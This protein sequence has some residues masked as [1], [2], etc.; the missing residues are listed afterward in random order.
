MNQVRL[1][2]TGGWCA[3][4][5]LLMAGCPGREFIA[6]GTGGTAQLGDNASV[7]V[8]SPTG[9]LSINGGTPVEVAWQVTA[10]T[11]F[12]SIDVIFDIDGNPD[13]GNEISAQRNIPLNVSSALLST[14]ELD[15]ATYL[16][17]VILK[18][19]NQLA[20]F[21]YAPGRLVVN[22]APR[23]FFT[24]PRDNFT[25][26]RSEFVVPR[27]DVAWTLSDPDSDV[28]VQI[29][30]DPD[31]TPNGN[32]ILLRESSSP[33]GDEFSFDLP[34]ANFEPGVYRILAV[35]SDGVTDTPFY[36][37]G[38][39]R[40][41]SRLAGF[42]DL[43]NLGLPSSEI[44][45]A[46]FEGFNPRDNNGSFVGSARDVDGDGF[47]DFIM[48][49]QFGKP[50]FSANLQR[51]GV[52]EAYM[53]Y[54]RQQRFS[55]RVNVNSVGTLIRGE[56]YAGVPEATDPIRPSR[57]IT[58]FTTLSDWDNDGLREVAFGMPFTDSFPIVLLDGAGY[59]RSGCV[60][61]QSSSVF[62][63]NLGFPGS[64]PRDIIQLGTIGTLPHEPLQADPGCPEGFIGPKAPISTGGGSTLYW[65]HLIDA[66]P[67]TLGG[68][69]LGCRYS[70]EVFGDQ[71]GETVSGYITD[72][73][74]IS[75]PNRDPFVSV[76]N[77]PTSTPGA[78]V[79]SI[80]YCTSA[81]GNFPWSN[82]DSPPAGNGYAGMPQTLDASLIPHGGPYHY[83]M[84]SLAGSPGYFVDPDDAQDPCEQAFSANAPD[85]NL[86]VR[87]FAQSPGARLGG[88]KAIDDF[89]AD[90]VD[91][92]LIGTPLG[93]EGAGACFIVL[94]RLRNL[95]VGGEL[96]IEELSLPLN[97]GDPGTS[98]IFDGIRVVGAPNS[99][100]GQSQ[101]R[102]G[103]F[104]GDGVADV[105][106][107]SPLINNR[108][109]GAAVFFGSR[110]VI[111]LT[112]EE[113]PFD[114]L[115]RR[116]LGVN[117]AGEDEG[118]LAGAR[119]AG[120]GDVDGDGN[121][122]I[123]IAAPERTVALDT[124]QNG[125]L[126][127]NRKNCG[128]VYL[129]YGSPDL[130]GTLSLADVGTERLPGVIFIG[131]NS[132]DRLGAA[133]GEQGD[134]S[135]GIGAAGDVDGDGRLDLMLSSVKAS[136]RD[137][138]AAGEVYLIYGSGD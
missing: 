5:A 59:F 73:I 89:N 25:F 10:T 132:A 61:V 127:I 14:S 134:R 78:G 6:G 111:N 98:R 39:I 105:V 72:S 119:V 66:Q 84:D 86:T 22:Q 20:A 70:S 60:V 35:V 83:V 106:I 21:D 104:N 16:I 24:S 74:I 137:R 34:T 110:D 12:A 8:L 114:D 121:D 27:F 65:R 69:R 116:G 120:V 53:I 133:I 64:S 108:K 117:F 62:S 3:A 54:G 9:D 124:D 46:I 42:I 129:I 67:P 93:F 102:A 47:G 96:S 101:D 1:L 63:P 29:F 92:I 135:V 31:R 79:V 100:L 55:G 88:A 130:R 118:D 112:Q 52:G 4:A 125:T 107:G 131:R 41:R 44:P 28:T 7:N 23:L 18:E 37:P 76:F 40:L 94:G 15:A 71:F 126:D 123:L 30:L 85:F 128:V 75:A 48:L 97:S 50:F 57:G 2:V 11:Q 91:D 33:T 113:L 49:A 58:S 136:P 90:G 109:G 43:R 103:D 82:V 56:V 32:E 122:D 80:Y 36:A 38:S 51:T 19:E 26:D 115:P 95:I 87:L 77:A 99:R 45:G 138:V 68:V 17:G 81:E 13:N